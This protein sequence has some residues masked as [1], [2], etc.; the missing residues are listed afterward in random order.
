V[1]TA[2]G[3]PAQRDRG[4]SA[5]GALEEEAI[6]GLSMTH[7]GAAQDGP[8]T[9]DSPSGKRVGLVRRLSWLWILVAGVGSYLIVLRTLAA[10][11]NLNFIPSLILLGSAVVPASVLAFAASGGRQVLVS[12][13]WLTLIALTGGII[14]TVAAATLPSWWPST[15]RIAGRIHRGS[16]GNS[17]CVH[18]GWQ[19][20]IVRWA[21]R[22]PRP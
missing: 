12:P 6:T 13:G 10:T 19:H 9:T 17:E 15:G 2:H 5:L 7:R 1:A 11:E 16:A 21:R 14:G 3:L 8:M 20:N 4:W 22:L 18:P